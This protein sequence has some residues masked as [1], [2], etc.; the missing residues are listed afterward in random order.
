MQAT[1]SHV[2][3]IF[4]KAH[5]GLL[6]AGLLFTSGCCNFAVNTE[7][8]AER[9]IHVAAIKGHE[10]CLEQFISEEPDVDTPNKFGETS[11]HLAVHGGH[12][13][14]SRL[15]I[16]HGANVNAAGRNNNRAMHYCMAKPQ[17]YQEMITLLLKQ[18]AD[19]NLVNLEGRTPL[20]LI[21]DLDIKRQLLDHGA[22]PYIVDN[23]GYTPIFRDLTDLD[24]DAMDYLRMYFQMGLDP[25]FRYPVVDRGLIHWAIEK[26]REDIVELVLE[27]K[28]NI[29][30]LNQDGMPAVYLAMELRR[31]RLAVNLLKRGADANVTRMFNKN[32]QLRETL[33]NAAVRKFDLYYTVLLLKYGANPDQVGFTADGS[34]ALY[35]LSRA[36]IQTAQSGDQLKVFDRLVQAKADVNLVNKA[37]GDTPL[38][39]AVSR[40]NEP[41]VN[42]LLKAGANPNAPGARGRTPLHMAAITGSEVLLQTLIKHGADTRA[43]DA[44]GRT[45]GRAAFEAGYLDIA[46]VL[47]YSPE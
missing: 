35:N 31:D 42:G 3:M 40:A 7:P 33:L 46:N 32:P 45:P 17:G 27:N 6:L 26:D 14:S 23:E 28:G 2:V 24:R 22:S 37:N 12:P 30:M 44:A 47:D 25:D 34:T 19:L 38:N 16:R 20:H 18:K 13:G 8:R 11:L 5:T 15:L 9:P 43:K 36:K 41:L 10:K 1:P 29:N 39:A 4:F 21:R